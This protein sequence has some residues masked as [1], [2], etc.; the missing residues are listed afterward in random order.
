MNG[1]ARHILI[2]LIVLAETSAQSSFGAEQTETDKLASEVALKFDHEMSAGDAESALK[3]VDVP[4]VIAGRSS[5]VFKD[6]GELEKL[7]REA[8]S[9]RKEKKLSGWKV[10]GVQ[11]FA[12]ASA[13]WQKE[14][15]AE[16]ADVLGPDDRVVTL[17]DEAGAMTDIYV[18]VKG[19]QAFVAGTGGVYA[20]A[21]PPKKAPAA[22]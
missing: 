21:R 14:R 19:K 18:R 22:K 12:K 5:K 2:V 11:T 15:K 3:M 10:I 7:V 16:F 4:F 9:R 8:L 17:G 1:I 20:K 6:R 13:D